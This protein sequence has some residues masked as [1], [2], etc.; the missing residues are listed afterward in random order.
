MVNQSSAT[1]SQEL[2]ETWRKGFRLVNPFMVTMFRLGLGE[3]VNSS[4]KT[5]GRIMVL[6][7]TGRK[8]GLARRT[9][10]NYAIVDGDVY[11]L[12]GFGHQ[13]DWYLNVVKNP[14]VELWMPEGWWRGLA[15]DASNRPDR[16]AL[17]REVIIASGLPGRLMGLDAAT[18]SDEE[19]DRLT[20]EARL[21][22]IR[23]TEARTGPGG[24]GDLAWIWPAAT[25]L[26]LSMLLTRPK[27]KQRGKAA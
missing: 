14:V 20:G 4:P 7:H 22:R 23:R 16:L 11:C 3:W 27:K 8:S 10:V 17:K 12:A 1:Q 5:G 25:F 2:N 13:S 24:P 6:T 18:M 9:P 21:I 15:E 19:M 26:L